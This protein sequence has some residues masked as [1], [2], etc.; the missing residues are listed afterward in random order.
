[1]IIGFSSNHPG[2]G[3][4]TVDDTASNPNKPPSF[5]SGP[6]TAVGVCVYIFVLIILL[7]FKFSANVGPTKTPYDFVGD[8]L[9][10]QAQ[11]EEKVNVI[12]SVVQ[13]CFHFFRSTRDG[14]IPERIIL[15]RNGCSEGQ[16]TSV[17]LYKLL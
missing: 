2:G 15:F 9:Y 12:E 3:I 6:P 5:V 1:M 10:Q 8:F 7:I 13:R 16:Y 4:G 17:C 11:R 14:A